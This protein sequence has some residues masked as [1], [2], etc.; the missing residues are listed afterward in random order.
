[1][2]FRKDFRWAWTH[3]IRKLISKENRITEISTTF[4]CDRCL[5]GENSLLLQKVGRTSAI[6]A[7]FMALGLLNLCTFMVQNH[8][9]QVCTH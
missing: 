3:G 9:Q 5:I 4:T 1:M 8:G 2:A 6:E 7:S